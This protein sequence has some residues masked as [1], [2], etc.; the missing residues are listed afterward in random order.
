MTTYK[1]TIS[2]SDFKARCSQ[3][4]D[5]VAKGRGSVV[6]TKRGRPVA[7]LIPADTERKSIFGFARGSI[8]IHGDIVEPI[9]VEW[10]AS[11]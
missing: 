4:I 1:K 7:K 6:I 11:R 2:A 10:E 3:V 9:D 8:T 5:D